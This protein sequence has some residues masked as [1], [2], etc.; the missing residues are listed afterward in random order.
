MFNSSN[1]SLDQHDPMFEVAKAEMIKLNL[2]GNKSL[3]DRANAAMDE[4]IAAPRVVGSNIEPIYQGARRQY[5]VPV[6]RP[7][8]PRRSF[9]DSLKN[10]FS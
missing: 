6:G 10:L 2:F 8:R 7:E 4:I 1:K 9:M 5:T 3:E